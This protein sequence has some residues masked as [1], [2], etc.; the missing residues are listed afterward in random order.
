MDYIKASIKRTREY[1]NEQF[2]NS[3]R[4]WRLKYQGT[5][6]YKNFDALVRFQKIYYELI[7]K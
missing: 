7:N 3:Y 6:V 1:C 5:K 4:S 2:S